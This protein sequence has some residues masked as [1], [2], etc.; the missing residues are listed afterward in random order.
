MKPIE[1]VVLCCSGFM[2]VF[3]AA[4]FYF[5]F[6]SERFEDKEKH[7]LENLAHKK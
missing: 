2:G 3:A 4:A 1:L 7:K 6:R 5:M